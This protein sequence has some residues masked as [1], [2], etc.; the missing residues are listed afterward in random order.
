[1]HRGLAEMHAQGR[2]I[3]LATQLLHPVDQQLQAFDLHVGARE[4]VEDRSI[5]VF[6]AQEAS[7]QQAD[8][9]AVADHVASILQRLGF[10][11]IQKRADHDR[12]TGEA[13]GLPDERGMRTLAGT[14][15]AS[16]KDDLLRELQIF[17]RELSLNFTPHRAEDELRILDLEVRAPRRLWRIGR[18]GMTEETVLESMEGRVG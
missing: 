13:A 12:R 9:F 16:E 18:R 11:R 4:A 7:E 2:V 14:G 3:K 17:A 1:M 6:R 5:A 15:R 8:H 10:G